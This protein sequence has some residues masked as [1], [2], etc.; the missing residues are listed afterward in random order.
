MDNTIVTNNL[1]CFLMSARNDFTKETLLQVVDAFYSHE[2]VK[3]AKICLVDILHKDLVW[4]RDPGKKRKDLQDV[5]IFLEE[6]IAADKRL[7]FVCDSYK[8]MPPVGLEFI[9][10]L[11]IKLSEDVP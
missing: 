8:G 10:P 6:A 5:M 9:A 7:K 1:L 2:I 3:D 4:R 11:I